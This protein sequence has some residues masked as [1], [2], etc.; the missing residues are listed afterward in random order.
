[1][2]IQFS[3][4]DSTHFVHTCISYRRKPTLWNHY[5]NKKSWTLKGCIFIGSHCIWKL[6]SISFLQPV[7]KFVESDFCLC[8][9]PFAMRHNTVMYID[10]I[11]LYLPL[12]YLCTLISFLFNLISRFLCACLIWTVKDALMSRPTLCTLLVLV[13]KWLQISSINYALNIQHLILLCFCFNPWVKFEIISRKENY[14]HSPNF[15]QEVTCQFVI[16]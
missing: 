14:C 6:M 3:S 7:W 15:S 5:F 9:I 11:Q 8:A 2:L 10:S 16:L 4:E 1:M 13:V 12:H